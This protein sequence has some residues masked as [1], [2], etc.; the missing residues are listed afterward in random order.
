MIQNGKG[1]DTKELSPLSVPLRAAF[2]L[3]ADLLLPYHHVSRNHEM[4]THSVS[5]VVPPQCSLEASQATLQF[6]QDTVFIRVVSQLA[7]H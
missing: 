4:H 7:L 3:G 1:W 6:L 2:T 5:L